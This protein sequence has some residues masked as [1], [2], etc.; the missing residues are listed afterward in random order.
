VTPYERAK[1]NNPND[2]YSLIA[3]LLK[4]IDSFLKK[5][6]KKN[7]SPDR[8]NLNPTPKK[9]GTPAFKE[10]LIKYHVD[11]QIKHNAIKGNRIL[12]FIT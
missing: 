8:K 6:I 1:F 9:G 4:G 7:K 5:I 10:I 2:K 12:L 11:P 3:C